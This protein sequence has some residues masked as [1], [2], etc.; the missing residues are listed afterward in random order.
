M[1]PWTADE[2]TRIERAEEL[3][4]ASLRRDGTLRKPV[5]VWVVRHGDDLYIR[6]VKGAM[7]LG[8]AASRRRTKVGYGLAALRK[9]LLSWTA[10]TTMTRRSMLPIVRNIAGTPDGFS[11]AC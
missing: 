11:T 4:I 1:T 10:A 5:T 6:S 3:E 9:T 8:S 2:L 7:G